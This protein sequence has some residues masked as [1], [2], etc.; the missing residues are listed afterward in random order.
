MVVPRAAA[1]YGRQLKILWF[2]ITTYS[3]PQLY[4]AEN[5]ENLEELT[6]PFIETSPKNI[7]SR[8]CFELDTSINT[9]SQ[10]GQVSTWWLLN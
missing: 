3:D 2:N 5:S 1:A 6:F 8:E 9:G 10:N 4:N 7:V